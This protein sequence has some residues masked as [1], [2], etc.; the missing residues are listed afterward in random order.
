M[1]CFE[2]TL[3]TKILFGPGKMKLLGKV[4]AD[5]GRTAMLV[6]GKK[7]MRELGI[8]DRAVALM[9]ES[10]VSCVVFDRAEPNPR[11]ATVDA[12][13]ALARKE[14]VDLVIALGG[15]SAIDMAKGIAVCSKTGKPVFDHVMGG[16]DF[17][18]TP[19]DCALPII[20]VPTIAAAGSEFGDGAV[21]T[22]WE[23]HEKVVL[24]GKHLFPRVLICDPEL[25]V[26]VP[27]GLS[28]DGG[29][30]I[31]AHAMDNYISNTA[32]TPLQD[33]FSES[34]MKTIIAYLPRVLEDGKDLEARTQVLWASTL[35]N[36]WVI[37]A[38]KNGAGPMH[39]IEHCLS[40]HYDISHGRGLGIIMPVLWRFNCE[41][42]PEKYVKVARG[43]FGIA[44]TG[45]N[46]W[47]LGMLAIDALEEW[48][49]ANGLYFRLRDVGI[50]RSKFKTIA[51][52]CIRIY[53]SFGGSGGCLRNPRRLGAEEIVEVLDRAL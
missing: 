19:H 52:D 37:G 41:T 11:T 34:V 50:D 45:L 31:I 26:S 24:A 4:A 38:G 32:T 25:T 9:K 3:E 47:E 18:R 22:R 12:G 44:G 40:G 21:L 13:A 10:G 53:E 23:T 33:S 20:A 46:D 16:S 8:L 29:I 51:A 7:A 42:N 36:S 5:L 43:V 6:T 14:N 2:L 17:K 49:K 1:E 28:G 35:A 27:R 39:F 15:G 30:D 48:M